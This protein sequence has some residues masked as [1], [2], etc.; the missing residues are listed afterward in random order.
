VPFTV[1]R[2]T[3]AANSDAPRRREEAVVSSGIR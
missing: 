3:V 2:R 1:G